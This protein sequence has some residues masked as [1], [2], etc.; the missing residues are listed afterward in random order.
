MV[1]HCGFNLHLSNSYWC[2]ASLLSGSCL[3]SLEKY[4][5]RFFAHF[6][7]GL[8]VF[9]EWSCVSSLYILEI[10]PLSK[11]SFANIFSYTV[12]SLFSLMMFSLPV[13]KTFIWM[14]SHLF[15]LSFM[16]LALGDILVKI[17]LHEICEI[18]LPVFSSRIFMVW[19]L[20][21][22]PFI[23]FQFILMY[24]VRWLP[25]FIFLHASFQ[26]SQH[27]LL[28]RLSLLHC[29]LL[30]P[31]SNID[32]KDVGL[33]LDFLFCSIDLCVCSYASTRLFWLLWP[34]NIV[35]CQ[36]W[37]SLLLCSSFSK[38]PC[39][40]GLFT[41]PYTFLKCLFYT[42]EICFCYFNRDCIESMN[43]FG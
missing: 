30:P 36:I 21:F 13:Q 23:H 1:S 38:L 7:I 18:F 34:Y 6:L 15:I 8:F 3:S 24:G 25:S 2:W 14:K 9:L 37:R 26:F 10:K 17:L 42:C 43:C 27:Y 40:S 4:L 20:I 39:Y 12:G 19:K 29:K 33:F 41:V 28:K 31:L 35:W 22:K 5:F 32:H 16:F 11:I